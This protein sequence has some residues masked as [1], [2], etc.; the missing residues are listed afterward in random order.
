M[1]ICVVHDFQICIEYRTFFGHLVGVFSKRVPTQICYLTLWILLRYFIGRDFNFLDVGRSRLSSAV[2][3]ET[4]F[5][6]AAFLIAFSTGIFLSRKGTK[7][8]INT[9]FEGN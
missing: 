6:T 1:E 9:T 8:K 5:D 7:H 4:L 3:P 2:L